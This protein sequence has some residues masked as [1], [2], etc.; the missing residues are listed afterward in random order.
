VRGLLRQKDR[1]RPLALPGSP[2]R[3]PHAVVVR[4]RSP[5]GYGARKSMTRDSG[6]PRLRMYAESVV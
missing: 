2:H 1:I 6:G 4:K 5:E 3:P